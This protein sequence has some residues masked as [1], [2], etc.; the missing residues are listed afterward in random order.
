MRSVEVISGQVC[1]V[2]V[3]FGRVIIFMYG[4]VIFGK[5]VFATVGSGEV[6]CGT[7]GSLY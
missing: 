7:V 4:G 5:V 2:G 3:W 6:C 1:W